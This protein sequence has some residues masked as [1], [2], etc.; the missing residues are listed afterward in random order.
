M[1]LYSSLTD[2]PQGNGPTQCTTALC[3]FKQGNRYQQGCLTD[4]FRVRLHSCE[5]GID[6]KGLEGTRVVRIFP[7]AALAEDGTYM[8]E[9][10]EAV[11]GDITQ[12]CGLKVDIGES[13]SDLISFCSEKIQDKRIL[14]RAID[15]I[16][17][18]SE[19]ATRTLSLKSLGIH[20]SN[21]SMSMDDLIGLIASETFFDDSEIDQGGRG[22]NI[23]T[24]WEAQR[25]CDPESQLPDEIVTNAKV[26]LHNN[27]TNRSG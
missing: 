1:R 8:P 15:L 18:G 10:E 25:S 26:F 7:I 2:L 16:V 12:S 3:G 21:D 6:C 27:N 23:H 17:S 5:K 20:T 13:A 14:A 22:A 4:N 11:D 9:K 19:S 24:S